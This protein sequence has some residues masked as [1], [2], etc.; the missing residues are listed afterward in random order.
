MSK[1]EPK[2]ERF[3]QEYVVDLNGTQAAIRAGYSQKTANEQS[4]QLLA[5]LNIKERIEELQKAIADSLEV[6]A[7]WI[8]ERL[9]Q[10]A[11]RCMTAEPVM[12][13]DGKDMVASGEYKFDASGA[14]K[15]LELLGKRIGYFEK[16]NE[17]S[18]A[19]LIFKRKII[20]G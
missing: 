1:L 10:V 11:E 5:K 2:Q 13:R 19:T 17:Q 12:V 15:A 16:D 6:D 3:C 8:T 20:G 9:K 7:K 18:A 4:S 14:N